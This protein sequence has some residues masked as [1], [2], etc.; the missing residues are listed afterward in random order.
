M[1]EHVITIPKFSLTTSE[2]NEISYNMPSVLDDIKER[3]GL[4]PSKPMK[5]PGFI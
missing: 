1:N 3:L 5:N 2:L 4:D